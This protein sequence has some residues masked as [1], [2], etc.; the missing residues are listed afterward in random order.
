MI[1]DRCTNPVCGS[2]WVSHEYHGPN[3]PCRCR[4]N[5]AHYFHGCSVCGHTWS[6][7]TGVRK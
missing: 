1:A 7:P 3:L 6:E 2:E 5:G 4:E